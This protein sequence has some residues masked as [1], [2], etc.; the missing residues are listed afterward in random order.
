L[1]RVVDG[2]DPHVLVSLIHGQVRIL[3]AVHIT[4]SVDFEELVG[5][6][7]EILID[8]GLG[9]RGSLP[10]QPLV[11]LGTAGGGGAPDQQEEDLSPSTLAGEVVEEG[12][13]PR[14]LLYMRGPLRKRLVMGTLSGMSTTF[15]TRKAP[16]VAPTAAAARTRYSR[17]IRDLVKASRW[18]AMRKKTAVGSTSRTSR[19]TQAPNAFTVSSP[20]R[21]GS[22]SVIELT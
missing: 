6:V 12:D 13:E 14:V 15:A 7:D 19:T 2:H 18:N 21:L 5:D 17:S 8:D 10:A 11:G 3:G 1:V 16:T 22:K 20:T 9:R 4:E